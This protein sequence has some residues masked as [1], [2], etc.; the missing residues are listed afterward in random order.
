MHPI[1]AESPA[2]PFIAHSGNDIGSLNQP[3]MAVGHESWGL[4]S[5]FHQAVSTLSPFLPQVSSCAPRTTLSLPFGYVNNNFPPFTLKACN[6]RANL[7]AHTRSLCN[8]RSPPALCVFPSNVH[9]LCHR[10]APCGHSCRC[11][12]QRELP[13]PTQ[14]SHHDVG[15][16]CF[17]ANPLGSLTG[18]VSV[19]LIRSFPARLVRL[20]YW[21]VNLLCETSGCCVMSAARRLRESARLLQTMQ[22]LSS[23]VPS[24]SVDGEPKAFFLEPL[25][26]SPINR[27]VACKAYDVAPVGIIPPLASDSTNNLNRQ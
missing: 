15:K 23:W 11:Q 22:L 7:N 19:F 20:G 16:P 21:A 3:P 12:G 14:R 26:R 2:Q 1:C 9:P 24:Q 4:P 8:L 25:A 27:Y 13:V 6:Q 10:C 5:A 17:A 18:C